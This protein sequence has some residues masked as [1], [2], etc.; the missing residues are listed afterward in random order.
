M[1]TPPSAA[2]VAKVNLMNNTVD[3]F[4]LFKAF[5]GKDND[6]RYGTAPISVGGSHRI[7]VNTVE[8]FFYK[9]NDITAFRPYIPNALASLLRRA[10]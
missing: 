1:R 3:F 6:W 9:V 7:T 5:T 10:N 2:T 4:A 8:T